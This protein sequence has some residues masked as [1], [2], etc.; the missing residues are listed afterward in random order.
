MHKKDLFG[1]RLPILETERLKLRHPSQNDLGDLFAIFSNPAAMRY[2]SHEAWTDY[3][4][5][6]K[7]LNEI[8]KGF[9]DRTLF[10]WASTKKGENRL[11]GTVTL[12][13]WDESNR[14]IELGYM[15]HP[16]QWGKGYASEAVRAALVF[17]FEQLDVHR[18][19]AELD[20][21]NVPSTRLLER[22]GF[23]K[24]GLQRERW[25]LFDEWSDSALY[26]LLKREFVEK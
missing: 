9:S 26:G 8:N 15:L 5:A 12:V 23:R 1:D 14:H 16:D 18:V 25:F 10:Q 4:Q 24:E 22:L 6:K 7:Y 21:R 20:P 11:I 3:D 17:A 13:R 2:W 19:E